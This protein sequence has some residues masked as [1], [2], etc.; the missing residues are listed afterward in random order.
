MSLASSIYSA[1][2]GQSI[3]NKDVLHAL[4]QTLSATAIYLTGVSGAGTDYP[5]KLDVTYD[6]TTY[7]DG[8]QIGLVP[9]R[10]PAKNDSGSIR[11]YDS[12]GRSLPIFVESVNGT[13]ATV[14]VRVFDNLD[15]AQVI[16]MLDSGNVSAANVSNG[17]AVFSLFDHFGDGELDASKWTGAGVDFAGT[18]QNAYARLTGANADITLKS[19]QEFGDGFELVVRGRFPNASAS[20]HGFI[21]GFE[22][23]YSYYNPSSDVNNSYIAK[24]AL[25][26]DQVSQG[27]RIINSSDLTIQIARK[28]GT[29]RVVGANFIGQPLTTNSTSVPT[30]SAPAVLNHVYAT[31]QTGRVDYAFVRKWVG[32]TEPAVSRVQQLV[33]RHDHSGANGGGSTLRPASVASTGPISGTAPASNTFGVVAEGP[34]NYDCHGVLI[35]TYADAPASLNKIGNFRFSLNS[36]TRWTIKKDDTAETGSNAGSDMTFQAHNDAGSQVGNALRLRRDLTAAFGGLV[37]FVST[38]PASATAAGRAGQFTWDTSYLYICT[39][40]NT[41]RRVAHSTW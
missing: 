31:G 17:N 10:V 34:A 35:N 13:S 16:Y 26:S 36:S 4:Y 1:I 18:G 14:W 28:S 3:I 23:Q 12:A 8:I 15:S 21:A 19:I 24:G 9:A 2:F 39:A 33:G 38:P 40:T 20:G 37:E 30:A 29:G 25:G 22:N 6:G 32:T 11:F 7:N 27:N 41:W 5:V